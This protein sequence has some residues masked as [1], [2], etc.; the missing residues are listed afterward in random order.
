MASIVDRP[1]GGGSAERI[2]DRKFGGDRMIKNVTQAGQT[3]SGLKWKHS[4]SE[5][6][7]V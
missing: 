2:D 3:R 1:V 4:G 6:F 5:L 7:E